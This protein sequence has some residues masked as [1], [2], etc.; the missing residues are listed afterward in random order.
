MHLRTLLKIA[1]AMTV[2][3]GLPALHAQGFP[4]K[5]VTMVVPYPAGGPSDYV[6]RQVQPELSKALNQTVIVDNVGGVGGAIAIQKVLSAPADG[7]LL[8]LGTPMELV[9]APLAMSAV[10]F[11]PEDMKV[12]ARIGTT[13]MVLLTRKDLPVNN[14]EELVALVKKPGTK[15][16]SYGSVGPGSLYHLIGEKFSQVTGAKMLHV[17]YKGAAPL[18]TDL[19]GGQIDMVFI[20]LAG[21]TPGM[22]A[23]GKVKA[24]GI[25]GRTPH[26]KFP[27]LPALAAI[28]GFEGFEFDIWAGLQV[29]AK[30]PADVTQKLNKA[31]YEALQNSTLRSNLESTGTVVGGA[32]SPDELARMY[33]SEIAR[34]Q[35]IAKSINLQPQ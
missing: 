5:P 19:M 22:I 20:P 14:F 27:Q 33:S 18:I 25:T 1:L 8:T 15:E 13:S 3:C 32:T 12:V 23:E 29:P 4:S 28:K 21:G 9:L 35:A 34:Y 11:K 7:H 2:G 26:P 10:K 17:A 30:T 6:A 24:M 31:I 16:L